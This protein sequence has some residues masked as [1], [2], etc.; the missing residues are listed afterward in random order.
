MSE[1]ASAEARSEPTAARRGAQIRLR[2]IVAILVLVPSVVFFMVWGNWLVGGTGPMDSI[3]GPAVAML[4]GLVALNLLLRRYRP[5][6]AFSP[7]ELITIYVALAISAGISGG[8]WNWGGN[9]A[10]SIAYPI[11]LAGPANRWAEIMWPYLPP[12][13]TV[14]D[15]DALEG[16]F[17]GGSSPYQWDVLAAW[18]QP[19]FWWTAWLT[20]TLWVTMCLSVIVRRRWNDEEKLPFPMTVLPLQLV[21]PGQQIFHSPVWW[22][23]VAISVGMGLLGAINSFIPSVP[24]IPTYLDISTFLTNNRPWDAIR[25]TSLAWGPWQL[26]L[27][28]LMPVDLTFSLIVF[29]LLWRAEYIFFRMEGWLTNPWGGFPYGNQQVLGGYLALMA[30]VIWLD[31]QYLAQVV[32][33]AFGL[34]SYVSDD[35]EAFGYRTAVFGAVGGLAFLWWFFSRSGMGA[36]IIASFLALFFTM[37]MVMVRLRAQLGPPSH[38]MFG[39]MPEFV[40]TQF[41]GTR[42]IGPGGLGLIAMLRP[43]MY[44]QD[45]EPAPAQLEALRMA[46]RVNAN[47]SR[48]AWVLIAVAP[49][50]M[51][52]YF[53][54]NLHVGYHVGLGSKADPDMTQ[55]CRQASDKLD[56]WLRDPGGANWNGFESIGI[57]FAITIMLMYVKLR[58]PL[59]PLHPLAFP[60][61]FSWTIDSMLPAVFVTWVFKVLLLRYGGLRAHRRALPFFLGLLAGTAVISLLQTALLRFLGIEHR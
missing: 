24:T 10:P 1:A 40:L 57:G 33:K 25:T 61:A 19:V 53:W 50:L 54:A 14:T 45:T 16:F 12:G 39:T 28:Y 13:L 52:C 23:G 38:W 51:L 48:I 60:L 9:L 35:G 37:V 31:R 49:L 7:G 8:V 20:G 32:R 43:F 2:A 44:E 6:W 59:W 55:V 15:R 36:P 4:C 18:A 56:D 47:P 26:G 41:P 34:P 3:N 22:A 17:L 58:A 11:W 29:N 30:S 5:S 21:D 42:A 46:S 27:S